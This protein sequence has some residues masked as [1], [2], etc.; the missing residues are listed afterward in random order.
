MTSLDEYL[1]AHVPGSVSSLLS[2][3]AMA[4]VDIRRALPTSMGMTAG[5]NTSGERQ[6]KV[7]VYANEKFA[8][9]LIGTGKVAEVASEE[10]SDALLSDGTVHVAMDP[11]DG[12]SNISTNNP[13]GSIF[14]FYSSKL[15]CSG[16]RL[17]AAAYVTYGPMLTI[18]FATDGPVHSFAAIDTGGMPVFML[19][20]DNIHIPAKPEVFGLGG[21]RKDWIE[22]VERFVKSLE[23]RGMKLRYGGTFVGDY[24][25]ILRYGGIFGYP[26]LKAKPKGKL[27]I[28]YEAAPMAYIT[29]HAGGASSD[30][31]RDILS[32]KPT[33]LAEPTPLYLGSESLVKEV[34]TSISGR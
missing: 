14:G 32:L 10:M 17:V 2:T 22:P 8:T 12:S 9:A 5:T 6:A 4:S 34:E 24:N 27:R 28:L 31:A 30:G 29:K 13:L 11:L 33:T 25:Q 18:T 7:D 26:A 23:D 21:Q 1:K 20:E 15:P 3:I 16:D 19:L